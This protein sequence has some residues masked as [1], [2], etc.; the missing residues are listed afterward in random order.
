MSRDFKDI[1]EAF[2]R[3]FENDWVEGEKVE[4]GG[5]GGD[6]RGG[7]PLPP[8]PSFDGWWMNRRVW[9][10][11]IILFIFLTFNWAVTT[12]TEWLWFGEL[13]YQSVWWTRWG[14]QI[15]SFA[16]FFLVAALMLWGNWRLAQRR[17]KKQQQAA[18]IRPLQ[19]PGLNILTG[20]A[21]LF[22]AFIFG[23]AGSSQ[24]ER[25]LQYVY[26]VDYGVADPIFNRDISFFLFELPFYRF[27]QGWMMPILFMAVLGSVAIY[28]LGQTQAI[29]RGQWRPYQLP[30]LR[31]H[32]AALLAVFFGLWA[33]GYWL[34]I[35]ELVYSPGNVVYGATHADINAVRVALQIQLT[36]M[37][38]I[39][40]IAAVNIFRLSLRPL[41]AAGGLWLAATILVAG[42]YP[43]LVQRFSVDPNELALETP[44]IEHNIHFTRMG[45]GLHEVTVQS[46]GS[47]TELSRQ[48]IADND[49]AMQN[50]RLWDYRPLRQTYT[51]LQALR[52]YYQFND[53]D[54]DRYELDGQVRQVMLS[55]R[56]LEKTRLPGQTWVNQKLEFTHGY[57]IAMNPVDR[58]TRDGQPEFFI[59]DL[60]PRSVIDLEVTRP[61]IYY[62][63]LTTD[64][65]YVA[66]GLE[67][68]SYPSDEEAVYTHYE[69]SGGVPVNN[70]LRRALF[71]IRFGDSNL[72]LS[73][74]IT[75]DTRIMYHR[76]IAD[77]VRRVAPFLGQDTDPY[78][79]VTDDGR[80]VWMIDT[81]TTSGN[82]PYST[83]VSTR[84][85]GRFNYIRNAVK[86]TVDAYNGE[87]SLYI[88]DES[89]PIIQTYARAFPGLFK[90]LEEMPE[91]L[92]VHIRYPEDLFTIQTYQYLTYHMTNVQVFYNREDL[93]AIPN[94]MFDQQQQPMEPY[95]VLFRLPD[96]PEAEYLLIQ[97][98]VPSNRDNMIAWI[99]ARNDPPHY[100]ELVA[101][102]LP[103]QELVFG[104][105]QV[106][107][108][109]D[110]DPFISQQF[111][112]WSQRGSRVIRGNLIVIP[113][114]RSFLYVEPIYLQ[115]ETS[116]LPELRRVIVASGEKVVMRETLAEALIALVED[117]PAVDVIVTEPP[118][119][120][121]PPAEDGEDV[122]VLPTLPSPS[123]D[124]SVEQLI[125]AANRHFEAAEAAQRRGD[126]AAY[127]R[128]LQA[129]GETLD[130]LLELTNDQ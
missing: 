65:V 23:L 41:L 108:R 93:R 70:W 12:Y 89:D 124:A 55:A 103:R 69:G 31:Q 62:G 111:S 96:E 81:Y 127:G 114:N 67:E 53:I 10:G 51:Q 97:P 38:L 85:L 5:N 1:P 11:G 47:T 22:M 129:L 59:R 76:E 116:A 88:A 130:R 26:R 48:D 52:P 57:G 83:P 34:D 123:L 58:V 32:A 74:Y 118:V 77:R 68:F 106:E 107:A 66:S 2:R 87:V 86:V 113:L 73:Q 109:I 105:I 56:E 104:P 84:A 98:F 99:A 21:A 17:A 75:N 46:F 91:S 64:Q 40:V 115:A 18:G 8:T 120:G 121:L 16:V 35:Y 117:Q 36:L 19:I 9:I 6:D 125:E 101:Y 50:I 37:A 30:A 82:F 90:P 24:W 13:G 28:A 100:G 54:I 33:V 128:E 72:I 7:R 4:N 94:E 119:E 60:P 110:Q 102:E 126:W 25:I 43:G 79:V 14:L 27:L 80:L 20:M 42:I 71:A 3:A 78:I 61:E 112:L 63:E 95:Y 44:Y 15:G 29:Q 49:L 122:I 92:F 39:A 45:Y